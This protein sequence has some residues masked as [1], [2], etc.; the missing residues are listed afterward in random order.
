MAIYTFEFLTP[1][2]ALEVLH[3]NEASGTW[4]SYTSDGQ[5]DGYVMPEITEIYFCKQEEGSDDSSTPDRIR[6]W[7]NKLATI[8]TQE[9]TA[10]DTLLD[11][12][13]TEFMIHMIDQH[14]LQEQLH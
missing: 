6:C 4:E 14:K 8:E 9:G 7:Y 1:D 3:Y 11:E 2:G 12:D 5:N 10:F 13:I